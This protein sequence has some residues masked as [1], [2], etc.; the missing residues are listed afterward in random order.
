MRPGSSIGRGGGRQRGNRPG[1][2]SARRRGSALVFAVFLMASL[3]ALGAAFLQMGSSA[4]R[5]VTAR[6]NDVGA[7]YV[8]EV[9]V[10]EALTA[11]RAG[12]TGNVGNIGTPALVGDGVFWVASS[13]L[14][15]GQTRLDVTAL[16][17]SGRAGLEVVVFRAGPPMFSSTI[18]SD[19]QLDLA[20]D[21]LVDSYDSSLGDYASQAVNAW[22]GGSWASANGNVRSNDDVDVAANAGIFGDAIPGPPA[23]VTIGAGAFVTGSTTPAPELHS[24]DNISVPVLASSGPLVVPQHATHVMPPGDYRF[25]SILIDRNGRIDIEGPAN[26]VVEDIT[27]LRRAQIYADGTAGP[28]NFFVEGEFTWNKYARIFPDSNSP[29]DIAFLLTTD[30]HVLFETTSQFLGGFYAPGTIVEI[31]DQCEFWGAIVADQVLIGAQSRFHYDEYLTTRTL[32][33]SGEF[34]VVAW[35]RRA[36]ALALL[37]TDRSDP[38]RLLGLDPALLPRPVDAWDL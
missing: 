38:F 1:A 14:G 11:M 22:A 31:Q 6:A 19:Q 34:Q 8:A 10:T 36:P 21:A 24:P 7:F 28:V 2:G 16:Q 29:A 12:A 9:G 4:S 17:G 27:F 32:G 33:G 35:N 23:S 37:A 25:D 3:M 30:D 20:S 18:F 13:P 15:N 5:A 26:V